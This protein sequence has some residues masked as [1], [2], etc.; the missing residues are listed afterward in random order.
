MSTDF[1]KALL[2]SYLKGRTLWCA[3][4]LAEIM[5]KDYESLNTEILDMAVRFLVDEKTYSV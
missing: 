5:P 4:C 3:A 1:S 2:S